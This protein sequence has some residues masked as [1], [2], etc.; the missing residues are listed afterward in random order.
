MAN[1]DTMTTVT[2]QDQDYKQLVEI[3]TAAEVY[4]RAQTPENLE[5]LES[6]CLRSAA[7]SD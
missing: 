4:L 3:A 7:L 5:A 6:A 1:L 2:I